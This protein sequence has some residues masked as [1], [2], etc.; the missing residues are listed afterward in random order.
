MRRS[1]RPGVR[2]AGLP[3]RDRGRAVLPRAAGGPDLGGHLGDPAADHR[4]GAREARGGPGPRVTAA[5]TDGGGSGVAASNPP[6]PWPDL[7]TLYAPASVAVV[8]ASPRSSIAPLVRDNLLALGSAA[9]CYFVNPSRPEAWGTPCHPSLADLPEVP[10]LVVVAVNPLRAADIAEE[11]GALGVRALVIPGGGVVEGGPAAAAMQVAV[12]AAAVRYGMAVLGPNCMGI[13]DFTTNSAV[14]IDELSP[15]LPRGGIAA[16]AQSG[17]VANAFLMSGARTGYSRV[18]SCGAEAALDLCDHLAWSLDDPQTHG[19]ALFVEGFKRPE[20]FLALADRAVELDKPIALVKV[21]RSAMAGAAAIAHSGNLAG[22]DRAMDAAFEAAGVIRCRDLDEL[23]ETVELIDGARRTQRRVGRGR[24]ALVTVSTGEASL[25]ADLAEAGGFPL[26]SIPDETRA[27]ILEALPTMGFVANPLDPWGADDASA[28][29]AAAFS[30]LATSGAYD[31]LGLVHDFAYRSQASELE[32]CLETLA[33]LLS[34]MERRPAILPILVSLTSGEPPPEVLAT[35]DAWPAGGRPP[36]LRGATAA[37]A[38]LRGM[39]WWES[40]RARRVDPGGPGPRRAVWPALAADRTPF[41]W[42]TSSAAGR[43]RARSSARALPE[44]ESLERVA[45]AGVPTIPTTSAPSVEAAVDAW[46]ALGG[47][48]ALKLDMPGL[49]HKSEVGGVVL[50]LDDE[51]AVRAAAAG[52]LQAGHGLDGQARG[53][54]VQP[55]ASRGLEMIVGGRR[56]PQVGPLVV[57]GLGGV[58]AEALDDV[59]VALA[60]LDVAAAAGLLDRLRGAPLLDG[61]RGGPVV[62]R[63]AVGEVVAAVSRLIA[64]DPSIVEVDLNPV[65]AGPSGAV[66]VDAL[67]VIEATGS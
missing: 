63:L 38:A 9:R 40:A 48:I 12:G 47:P 20:R 56:D 14:Y 26:P 60:P 55:M 52:L 57:V 46:R 43:A 33:P 44:R 6:G 49:A 31:V 13:A 41:A 53:L 25:V 32:T 67:V 8:G 64:G 22:E 19:I 51:V 59:A 18:V 4:P 35:L 42:D 54:L 2:R 50:L 11:A 3:P 65:I 34:A 15:H 21:G 29:Y 61:F 37:L 36:V 5:P 39:A 10:E 24:T 1:C 27:E 62:D 45:A 17:S 7:R 58:L 28:A 66:A 30:A 16:I 23:L